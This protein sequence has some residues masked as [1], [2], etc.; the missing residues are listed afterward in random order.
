MPPEIPRWSARLA[1]ALIL[2]LAVGCGT[3]FGKRSFIIPEE[4]TP[5]EQFAVARTQEKRARGTLVRSSR[6]EEFDKA[7]AAYDAV[8]TRF[9]SDQQYVPAAWI[10]KSEL[11]YQLGSEDSKYFP[12]AL[13]GFRTA[14][15]RF[16]DQADIRAAALWGLGR[17]YDQL[18]REAGDS[19][20]GRA[21]QQNAQA[22]YKAI[23]DEFSNHEDPAIRSLAAQAK[24][25]Y[26]I[27][28]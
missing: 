2:L 25:R 1:T 3:L 21:S 16:A 8:I 11:W 5:G 15:D 22:A 6:V 12:R 19:K 13:K 26:R 27:V 28:R 10:A 20:S 18:A 7:V 4:N 24:L 23:I 17:T 9:P 14:A